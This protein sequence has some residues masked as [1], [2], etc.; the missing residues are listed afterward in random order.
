MYEDAIERAKKLGTKQ[1]PLDPTHTIAEQ[2]F[3]ELC[4][5]EDEKIRKELLEH[6]INRRDGKQ[7]C[8][9][10]SDYRRWAAW[11]EKQSF[12][13]QDTVKRDLWEYVRE[14]T[15]KFGRFPKDEDELAACIDYV[16]KR[17]KP[18]EWSEEDKRALNDAIVALSMYA[19]GNIPHIL[20]SQLLED[21]EKLKSLKPQPHWKP[22]EEQMEIVENL[23]ACEMPPRHKK[24]FESLYNDLKSL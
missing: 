5:S 20:P 22:S 1:C 11:L 2:I 10:A 23:L 17:Q 3:T 14:W 8:V 21:V 13:E 16:M 9:D 19:N 4:E 15:D 6:C 7:I 18:I 24:I 12:V